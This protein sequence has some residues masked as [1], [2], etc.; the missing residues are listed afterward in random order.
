MKIARE[1]LGQ[2][3]RFKAINDGFQ[4]G[5]MTYYWDDETTFVID[6]T[7]V[8]P[9]FEG[10]GVGKKMIL[11]AVDYAREKNCKIVPA[12]SFAASMFRRLPECADVLKS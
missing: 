2:R 11:S 4:V 9:A 7:G 12:C 5:E 3:G 6:H 8:A 1:D 10:Q